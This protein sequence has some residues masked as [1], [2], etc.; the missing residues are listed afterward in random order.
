VKLT[1][2]AGDIQREW[3]D[4]FANRREILFWIQ[5]AGVYTLGELPNVFIHDLKRQF[6]HSEHKEG[7]LLAVLLKP[8]A[9]TREI[10]D[11]HAEYV[12]E[13]LVAEEIQPAQSRAFDRLRERATEYVTESKEDD[14]HDPNRQRFIA[15]RPSLDE[16]F[17]RQQ[18]TL[19]SFL[20]GFDDARDILEWSNEMP[21]ATHGE[22]ES[23]LLKRMYREEGTVRVLTGDKQSHERTRELFAIQFLLP[24]YI[25]GVRDMTGRASEQPDAGSKDMDVAQA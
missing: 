10:P 1:A 17:E 2:D 22:I 21:L 4:G 19:E 16:L 14:Q 9:R 20:D 25:A 18:E 13:I 5:K 6:R 12:R 23:D 15:M 7:T 8:Y 3:L 11:E 24:A